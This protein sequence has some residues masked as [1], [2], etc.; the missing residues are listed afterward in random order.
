MVHREPGPALS[1]REAALMR[2]APLFQRLSDQALTALLATATVRVVARGANLFVQG[3]PA[4][5]FFI[6][7]D[8]WIKLY[9]VNREGAEA[10]VRV[11]GP[12][13]SFAEAAMFANASFPV[14]AQAVSD[15]RVLSL[16]AQA[17]RRSLQADPDAAFAMLG[18]LSM[19]LR[20]LIQ[21]IE[22]LQ[23]QSAPQRVGTFLLQSCPPGPGNSTFTLPFDKGLIAQKL[24]MKAETFS[25]ALGKLRQIG[26]ETQGPMVSIDDLTA[27]RDFC[28]ADED[29]DE[30]DPMAWD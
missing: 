20:S 16:T 30:T 19:R 24:G 14:C 2:E 5:R 3:E 6:L 29:T 21:Q 12:G 25:R 10:V 17:F 9:R 22:H 15:V 11:L 23:V 13:E 7:L 4:D 1:P 8:G 18:S 26:V 28:H 27:L